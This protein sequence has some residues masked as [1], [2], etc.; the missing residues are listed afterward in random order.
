MRLSK[1]L[2]LDFC[3]KNRDNYIRTFQSIDEGVEQ[4]DNLITLLESN[5][6]VGDDLIDYGMDVS[7]FK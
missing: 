1:R 4:F 7:E 2:A 5:Q 3:Y 6:I